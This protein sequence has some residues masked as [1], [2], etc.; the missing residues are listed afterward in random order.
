MTNLARMAFFTVMTLFSCM[1]FAALESDKFVEMFTP[2]FASGDVGQIK[3]AADTLAFAGV[4]DPKL[5]DVAEKRLM[6]VYSDTSK[7][8]LQVSGWLIKAISYS[9]NTKYLGSLQQIVDTSS[10]KRVRRYA[11]GG[12]ATLNEYARWNPEISAGLGNL[13]G[14]AAER[15]RVENMLNSQQFDLLRLG[16]KLAY[17]NYTHDEGVMNLVEKQLLQYY[18]T[19]GD[20]VFVDAMGHLC[21]ALGGSGNPAYRE[22]M[23]KVANAA[24]EKKVRKYGAR[25]LKNF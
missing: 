16:A 18:E 21:K 14:R 12:I 8:G 1:V 10:A 23:E 11:E 2:N 22:T 20:K 15:K 9:G 13:T 7:A 4:S 3:A 6:Q 25:Y 19:T 24:A 17:K 5:Y